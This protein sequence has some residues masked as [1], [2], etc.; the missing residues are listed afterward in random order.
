MS[1][2]LAAKIPAAGGGL[3]SAASAGKSE[4]AM[5]E[6]DPFLHGSAACLY[7]PG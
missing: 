7:M 2:I 4:N 6:L 3:R 1:K 5:A